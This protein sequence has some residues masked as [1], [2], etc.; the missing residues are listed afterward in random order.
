MSMLGAKDGERASYPEIV[1]ALSQHGAEAKADAE[2]LFRRMV[3]N[4]LIS[5]VDDHLR[6]HGFLW[7]GKDGWTL[8]PAYDLNPVPTDLKARILTTNIS[9]E[10]GT[11]SLDLAL[12][13]AGLFGL[14]LQKAKAVAA[15]VGA[16]VG[17]WR[18]VAA[19]VGESL[20]AID[21]MASAFE[22][23][24]LAAARRHGS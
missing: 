4:I 7:R 15:E 3:F 5:N 11:C 23:D 9:L 6:N 19:S 14:S 18:K 20:R 2:E 24:D 17:N 1:D 21:R 13:Q 12:E 8:S 22:H 10:E 16:A